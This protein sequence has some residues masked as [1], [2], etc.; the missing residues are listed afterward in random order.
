[1]NGKKLWKMASKLLLSPFN[2]NCLAMS[3]VRDTN[4]RLRR[5]LSSH[6][7]DYRNGENVENVQVFEDYTSIDKFR[8]GNFDSFLR[9][10]LLGGQI[11]EEKKDDAYFAHKMATNIIHSTRRR[12]ISF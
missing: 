9:N 4:D 5:T 11:N 6:M 10:I 8:S 12:P 3:L 2:R 7:R 1:M